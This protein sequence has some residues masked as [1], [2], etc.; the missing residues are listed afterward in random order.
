ML[1]CLRVHREIR[2]QVLVPLSDTQKKKKMP[3]ISEE[4]GQGQGGLKYSSW[5][6][7][8]VAYKLQ[9]E[10][11]S[12]LTCFRRLALGWNMGSSCYCPT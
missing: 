8:S 11:S 9:A 12:G 1:F 10:P 5:V 3:K 7:L 2:S 6:Q 4:G